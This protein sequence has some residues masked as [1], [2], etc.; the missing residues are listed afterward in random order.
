MY[1]LLPT[2]DPAAIAGIIT[3]LATN[4]LSYTVIAGL[5]YEI[6]DILIRTICFKLDGWLINFI[7]YFYGIDIDRVIYND[8]YYSFIYGGYIYR[9]YVYDGANEEIKF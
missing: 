6:G 8:K 3:N 9:L 4:I 5:L 1:L 2:F 7:K